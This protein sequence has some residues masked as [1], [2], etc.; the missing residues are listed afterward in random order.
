[1][2]TKL[3]WLAGVVCVVLALVPFYEQRGG[4]TTED[5]RLSVGLSFSPLYVY[6][7]HVERTAGSDISTSTTH[8]DVNVLSVSMGLLVVGVVLLQIARVVSKEKKLAG[9]RLGETPPP[10]P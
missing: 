8:T 10:I 1:M 7:K 9:P 3:I 2:S 6:E 4:G 5:A